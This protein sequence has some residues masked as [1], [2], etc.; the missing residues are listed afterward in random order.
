MKEKKHYIE[1]PQMK[2]KHLEA[3][4]VIILTHRHKRKRKRQKSDMM[5]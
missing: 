3:C 4:I 2:T 1:R 5:K